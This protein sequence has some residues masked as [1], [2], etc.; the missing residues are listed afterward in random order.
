MKK[1]Y[2]IIIILPAN[3]LKKLAYFF[4]ENLKQIMDKKIKSYYSILFFFFLSLQK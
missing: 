1:K 3:F 4:K 2:I